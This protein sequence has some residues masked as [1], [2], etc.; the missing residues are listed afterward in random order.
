[1][2]KSDHWK[3][4]TILIGIGI[5]ALAGLAAA[6]ILVQRGEQEENHPQLT[7]GDSVKIGLGVLGILRLISDAITK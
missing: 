5:G 7:A 6:Y 3:T 1:M 4:K 2:E